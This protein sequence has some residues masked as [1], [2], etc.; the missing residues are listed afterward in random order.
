MHETEDEI[1]SYGTDSEG[2]NILTAHTDGK[3]SYK[4]MKAILVT[5]EK[6]KVV[7]TIL[8]HDYLVQFYSRHANLRCLDEEQN[9][10]LIWRD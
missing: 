6:L 9:L 1:V 10:Y 5:F 8:P 3:Y 7:N 4:M 2:R